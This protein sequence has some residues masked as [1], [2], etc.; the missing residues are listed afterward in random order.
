MRSLRCSRKEMFRLMNGELKRRSDQKEHTGY[1]SSIFLYSFAALVFDTTKVRLDRYNETSSGYI[2]VEQ[3]LN[4]ETFWEN[5]IRTFA[6]DD[7]I[8][9]RQSRLELGYY[10]LACAH[11]HSIVAI[12]ENTFHFVN[13]ATDHAGCAV[14]RGLYVFKRPPIKQSH[15]HAGYKNDQYATPMLPQQLAGMPERRLLCWKCRSL[16]GTKLYRSENKKKG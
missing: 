3:S 15:V 11:C 2:R 7:A 13:E 6:S 10:D 12:T 16:F 1:W 8:Q 9:E 4:S 14:P 5:I